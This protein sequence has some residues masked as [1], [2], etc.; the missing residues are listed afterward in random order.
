[1]LDSTYLSLPD[2]HLSHHDFLFCKSLHQLWGSPTLL[3]NQYCGFFLRINHPR[4]GA[5][6]SSPYSEWSYT[7]SP[8]LCLH[9]IDRDHVPFCKVQIILFLYSPRAMY[10]IDN[11]SMTCNIYV[12]LILHFYWKFF[13]VYCKCK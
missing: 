7:F 12:I 8:P 9:R 13:L 10:C 1:M 11:L 3:F 5:D 6:R 4:H 2:I